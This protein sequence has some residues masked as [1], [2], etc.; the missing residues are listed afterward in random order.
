LT[1]LDGFLD[2]WGPIPEKRIDFLTALRDAPPR[3]IS[4][5]YWLARVTLVS[6]VEDLPAFEA[7]FNAWFR[8]TA[9]PAASEEEGESSAPPAN[10][11][12]EIQPVQLAE[13]TGKDASVHEL[14]NRRAFDPTHADLMELRRA[15]RE[16]L[17]RIR[18]RRRRPARRGHQ[19][20]L[21]RT[22][23]AA[24]RTGEVTHLARRARPHRA[25]PLLVLIDVS[26]SLRPQVP[27]YVRFAWA[28]QG[29]TF[30]FGTRLTR[31]T[32]QLTTRD[33]DQALANVA[34]VVEDA[35][36]GTRIGPA[37]QEFLATPRYADRARGALTIVL[38]DGL[39]RGDPALMAHAVRR[40][41]RLSHRLLWWTPLGL[42]PNYRP[43]TRGMAAI[44]D[45]LDGLAGARDLPSLLHQV[46]QL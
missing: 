18:S 11:P 40:L 17:P 31:I 21:R 45:D 16:H 37:L 13:G 2:D 29:E 35:D 25:R 15:V 33:V 32:H 27:D 14:L 7:V 26:G 24:T 5:L 9:R 20:D 1:V 4:A 23:R 6:S 38:S 41:A 12:G 39:E 28:A 8:G 22:L 36:G 10:Q 44:V 43:V 34:G 19:I 30:T 3:D 46:N 42:D